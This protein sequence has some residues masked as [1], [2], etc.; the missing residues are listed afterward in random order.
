MEYLIATDAQMGFKHNTPSTFSQNANNTLPL[1]LQIPYYEVVTGVE[2]WGEC[3]ITENL[4]PNEHQYN[5][6]QLSP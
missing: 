1:G 5:N 3:N 6:F 4:R 2:D